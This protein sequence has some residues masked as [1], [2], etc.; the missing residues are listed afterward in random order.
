M[1]PVHT[2]HLGFE[3]TVAFA[4]KKKKLSFYVTTEKKILYLFW[5]LWPYKTPKRVAGQS[6]PKGTF[7]DALVFLF[8]SDIK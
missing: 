1:L 8:S 4:G 7:M 2:S 6:V 3:T 5:S